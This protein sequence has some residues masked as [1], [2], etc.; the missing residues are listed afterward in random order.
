MYSIAAA[1]TARTRDTR[2]MAIANPPIPPPTKA[3]KVSATVQRSAASRNTSSAG[4]KS[5]LMP[6]RR[7]GRAARG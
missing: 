5:R 1:R 6:A 4:S 7:R 3:T 2:I